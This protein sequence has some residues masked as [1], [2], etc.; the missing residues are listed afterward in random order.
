MSLV[1]GVTDKKHGFKARNKSIDINIID[2]FDN[3]E[4]AK[5]W[6]DFIWIL[7]PDE[8]KGM[9]I[10]DSRNITFLRLIATKK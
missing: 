9:E 3:K 6:R 2:A 7:D 1:N 4:G 5:I 8:A 10:D